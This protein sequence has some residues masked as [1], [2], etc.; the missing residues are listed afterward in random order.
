MAYPKS[1]NLPKHTASGTETRVWEDL[2]KEARKLEGELDAKL[3][4]YGKLCT[5][6]DSSYVS[7]RGEGGLANDQL[8]ETKATE[9][10]SLLGRLS[11]VNDG[12]SSALSGAVDSRSH[13]LARHRD[14]LHEF[15]QEFRRL[16]STLGAARDRAELMGTPAQGGPG[17]GGVQTQGQS[18]LLLRE[19]TGIANS[20]AALDDVL[21]QADAVRGNLLEQRRVVD[22]IGDKLYSLGAKFPVV[23]GLLN[24]IRRKKSKDSIV[25]GT[26]IAVC[27]LFTLIY[28][29]NK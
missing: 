22:G 3:A 13:T 1:P 8:I 29:W 2:R 4:A 11:D 20:N 27:C 12:M 14:I 10:E 15:M 24:A 26:V 17:Y 7:K 21:G 23:N 16:S 25:L 28:W 19:R 18:A 9:I 5:G 6:Y